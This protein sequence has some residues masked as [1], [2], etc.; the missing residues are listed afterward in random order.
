MNNATS[1]GGDNVTL[2]PITL[3]ILEIIFEGK[4]WKSINT[5][6][7]FVKVC[8]GITLILGLII[9]R[10]SRNT[11]YRILN[12]ANCKEVMNL[13]FVYVYVFKRRYSDISKNSIY[14]GKLARS[15]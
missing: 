11:Y 3:P 13:Q 1:Y 15:F 10:T 14:Y 8:I 6:G 2:S 9:F 5:S 12:Y 4:F 7:S